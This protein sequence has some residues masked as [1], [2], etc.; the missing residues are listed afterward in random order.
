MNGWMHHF[1]RGA[2]QASTVSVFGALAICLGGWLWLINFY[3]ADNLAASGRSVML[4]TRDVYG[5]ASSLGEQ[6]N[7]IEGGGPLILYAGE[8]T[9]GQALFSPEMLS[10]EISEHF[11]PF[12]F[13]AIWIGGQTIWEVE[14]L[15]A[16]MNPGRE[17]VLLMP[18]HL[19]RF[20]AARERLQQVADSKRTLYSNPE[21]WHR[22][23]MEEDITAGFTTGVML[24]DNSAY[25]AKRKWGILQQILGE[26]PADPRS[27]T[28]KIPPRD[29]N[30][31][32]KMW[33]DPDYVPYS[34]GTKKRRTASPIPPIPIVRELAV[35]NGAK[36]LARYWE[37]ADES[38]AM[39][40]RSVNRL[41]RLGIRVILF[42]T[43]MDLQ[44]MRDYMG[45]SELSRFRHDLGERRRRVS[46]ATGAEL[47]DLVKPHSYTTNYFSDWIHILHNGARQRFTRALAAKVTKLMSNKDTAE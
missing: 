43:P 41:Q 14:A 7:R 38:E 18:L 24:F 19:P 13:R 3:D 22:I 40:I 45:D 27:W 44:A 36:R 42:D 17:R 23:L 21:H 33:K 46:A 8:S 32:R 15:A 16:M 31:L 39:I 5:Y 25:L 6:L 2:S 10:E 4:D 30:Q 1:I 37:L 11:F 29:M 35:I 34:D 12:D 47:I 20:Q 28:P 26:A 9:S